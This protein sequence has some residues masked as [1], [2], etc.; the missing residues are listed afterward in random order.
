[1]AKK[2][3][4]KEEK[5]ELKEYK[6][7]YDMFSLE[8]IVKIVSFFELIKKVNNKRKYNKRCHL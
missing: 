3:E 4:T 6:I 5:L 1:M 7:D 2:K 8:E